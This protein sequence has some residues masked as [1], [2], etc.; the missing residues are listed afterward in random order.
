MIDEISLLT[1]LRS[2]T[3]MFPRIYGSTPFESLWYR[4]SL[5]NRFI[6][7]KIGQLP[8]DTLVICLPTGTTTTMH[9]FRQKFGV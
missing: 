7:Y 6:Q 5:P 3:D 1:C 4:V 9:P 8:Y 2:T